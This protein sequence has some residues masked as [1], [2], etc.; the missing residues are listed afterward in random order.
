MDIRFAGSRSV[1]VLSLVC[2]LVILSGTAYASAL[3]LWENPNSVRNA[4]TLQ[5]GQGVLCEEVTVCKIAARNNPAY[6][7]I[8]DDYR[9]DTGLLCWAGHH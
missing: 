7:V 6:Y 2:L 1:V 3:L 9:P 5:E 8:G 4:L